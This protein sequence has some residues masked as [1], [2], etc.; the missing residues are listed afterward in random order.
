MIQLYHGSTINIE[1]I[2]LQKSRPNKDFGRG[3]YLSADRQQAWRM[4]EFKA[5]TEGGVPVMNTYLFDETV[6]VS[7][8]LNVL[9]FEGYT[10]EW[11]EFIFLNRNNRSTSPAHQYDIVYGPI[12]NDRVGVQIGKYEAGDITLEQFL[13]N[14]KYMKG[15]TF[16][17]FFGTERALAKLSKI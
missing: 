10:R 6:L 5:L 7:G 13:E 17:Y 14:L 4:G 8:E 1:R 15:V 2:N 16:Q 9:T 11:A 12:A 3:F